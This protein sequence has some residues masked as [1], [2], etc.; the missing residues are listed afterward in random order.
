MSIGLGMRLYFGLENQLQGR[1]PFVSCTS[2]D[3][4]GNSAVSSHL[5][6]EEAQSSKSGRQQHDGD[7]SKIIRVIYEHETIWVAKI[8]EDWL[9]T[10]KG[11][12][13]L[14]SPPTT[15]LSSRVPYRLNTVGETYA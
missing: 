15:P 14:Y 13:L 12:L 6:G 8:R 11:N 10:P 2:N 5:G 1:A 7:S 3:I 4:T 9:L